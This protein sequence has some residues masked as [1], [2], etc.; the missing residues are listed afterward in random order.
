M[1][2]FIHQTMQVKIAAACFLPS[3]VVGGGSL[4]RPEK[5]WRFFRRIGSTC[6][7][8]HMTSWRAHLTPDERNRM[9]E[10]RAEQFA[11]SRE[12][13]RIFDRARKRAQR[14]R[15]KGNGHAVGD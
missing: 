1:C 4:T 14:A 9:D 15:S 8:L 7:S 11:L 13:R 5:T 2:W 10:I 3:V 12:Y 6:L